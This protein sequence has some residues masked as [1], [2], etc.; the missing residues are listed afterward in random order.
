VAS[1]DAS[2]ELLLSRKDIH[3]MLQAKRFESM[4]VNRHRYI[5]LL[6]DGFPALSFEKVG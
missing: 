3:G 6:G 2:V 5:P 1:P 4:S